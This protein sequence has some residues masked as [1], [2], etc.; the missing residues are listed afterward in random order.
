MN[1]TKI[2]AEE[3]PQHTLVMSEIM[4]PSTAN[5]R[6]NVH[7]GDLL[8]LLDKVAYACASRYSGYSCVTLA[9]DQVFF[10]EPIYVGE[11]V[12]CYA[13]VNYVGHTSMEVGIK[14]VAENLQS[15][16]KRHTNTCYFIMVALDADGKPVVVKPLN[17]CTDE[18]KSRYKHAELRK[19]MRI[20]AYQDDKD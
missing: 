9:V 14:V 8:S 13:A 16:H 20:K 3:P 1:E 10:K 7:G 5:F 12:T 17:P 6:G 11:L 4:V 15:R 2:V 18:E 19:A